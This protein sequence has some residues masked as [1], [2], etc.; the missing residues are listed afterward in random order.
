MRRIT[1]PR[2]SATGR[3]ACVRSGS[4]LAAE[5]L[6]ASSTFVRQALDLV[7]MLERFGEQERRVLVVAAV[8]A[9]GVVLALGPAGDQREVL[10]PDAVAGPHEHP[11]QRDRGGGV[12]GGACVRQHLDHLGQAK[13]PREPHDLGG[14]LTFGE[15]LLQQEEQPR[16][17]AQHGD[18]GP[19]R[20]LRAQGTDLVGD[21]ARLGEFVAVRRDRHLAL[22]VG[23]E[24]H[25]VLVGVGPLRHGERRDDGIGG[26]QDARPT[27]EVGEQR[28]PRRLG[29]VGA[30]ERR[31]ELEQVVERGSAPRVDVLVGVARRR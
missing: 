30:P 23:L 8:F 24:R 6:Q 3:R 1:S 10:E 18:V 4:Q 14:D 13:Q 28:Q 15:R 26:V 19:R 9:P 27:A 7:E 17:A 21:P 11:R 20:S 16:G 31:G 25:E 5:L 12:V 2:N 29:T 22:A